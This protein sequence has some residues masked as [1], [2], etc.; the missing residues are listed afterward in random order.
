MSR[1]HEL[2]ERLREGRCA[3]LDS[4]V[5]DREPESLFLDFK[6]SPQDG[7]AKNLAPEDNK[8]LSKAISGFANS[9][10]GIVVW[11]VDCRRDGSTGSEVAEKH[12][13]L[14]AAGFNTKIQAAVS[15]TTIPPHPGVQVLSFDEPGQSP[16]GYVV[17]YIPQSLIGPIRSLATNHYHVRAGSDFGLVPH[18]VLAGMFGRPPQP[19][20]DLNLISH[21]A[22]LDSNPGHL[23][24][25]F[26][27]VA[28]NLGA[29]VGERPYLS[30]FI[31]D[32][33]HKLLQ[34]QSPDRQTFSVRRGPL[35]SFSVVSSDG[36]LLTPGAT[37]H[38]CDVVIDV[39]VASP[40][41]IRLECTLG[42][43]GAPPKR[44]TLAA[45]EASVRAG[46]AR[47]RGGHF[48]SSDVVALLPDW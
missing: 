44:F 10:G 13:L 37:E 41:P 1:A 48:P 38:M 3:A 18:D 19:N 31:G 26:G 22:R 42:V 27:F 4:L 14:D 30:A 6:R 21:P 43:L 35:P 40:R 2:F 33:P 15:R 17:V 28:V 8:N 39:P 5:A 46:I 20:A 12:P 36:F 16:L 32:F 11:G 29:V 24:V 25:A 45:S 7:A 34:V 9:S 23:T 47:A